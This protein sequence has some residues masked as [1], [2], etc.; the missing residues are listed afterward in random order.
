MKASKSNA[1][2]QYSLAGPRPLVQL[3]VPHGTRMRDL[4]KVQET[5][6]K[7]LLPKLSPRGCLPCISG[8]EFLIRE[9]LENIINVDLASG[10][11][12]GNPEI[13]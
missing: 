7:E 8:S 10:K 4:L 12:I 3:V 2:V 9:E 11:F 13:R 6:S 5:I 1:A